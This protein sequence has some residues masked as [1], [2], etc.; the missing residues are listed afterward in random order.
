[1][2]VFRA[3]IDP[4]TRQ[5]TGPVAAVTGGPGM[6]IMLSATRDGRIAYML[7]NAAIDAWSVAARPDEAFVSTDF[8]KITQDTMQKFNP[9]ISRDGTKLAFTAF[10]GLQGG[11]LELRWRDLS[12][13][14][15]TIL[16]LQGLNVNFGQNPRLSPDGTFLAYREIVA[17]K[18]RTFVV[19]AGSTAGT[20]VGEIGRLLDFFSDPGFALVQSKSTE[21]VKRNLKTGE[22][23]PLLALPAGFF[24]DGSLSADN[25]WVAFRAGLPDGRAS[26][27]VV[28][29]GAGAAS[30]KDVV[31]LIESD[32]YLSNPRWSPNGRYVYYLSEKS[33]RCGLYA[34]KFDPQAKKPLGD[35]QAVFFS[36]GERTN[37]NFP[38]GG[39][40]MDV[41]ADKIVFTVDEITGNIFLV[42]P[43]AR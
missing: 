8:R 21:L 12:S 6:K 23:A 3:S 43:V 11:R 7:A 34:Q 4:K 33:G 26:I 10:G 15:E 36:R 9:S 41:A 19:P 16:P 24:N 31:P 37:L 25:R 22:N 18:W 20:D 28:P 14:R 27:S 35:A 32:H 17:G 42:T 2:N 1:V 40:F 5:I 29:V 39:G 30:I 13:G 38:K